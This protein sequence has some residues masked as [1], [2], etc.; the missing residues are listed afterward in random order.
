MFLLGRENIYCAGTNGCAPSHALCSLFRLTPPSHTR[1]HTPS[2]SRCCAGQLDAHPCGGK[3]ERRG[4]RA[5]TSAARPAVLSD[6]TTQ[7][8]ALTEEAVHLQS[9][10]LREL[11]VC[12]CV[13][14]CVS[15]SICIYAH[16]PF[17]LQT[18]SKNNYKRKCEYKLEQLNHF[19]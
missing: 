3:L 2:H 11:C 12:V 14:V 19:I 9:K 6:Q 18:V 4:S 10:V 17:S 15:V 13:C 7:N 5:G 8:R 1:M 16:A